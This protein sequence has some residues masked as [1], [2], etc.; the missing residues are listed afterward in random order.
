MIS[1]CCDITLGDSYFKIDKTV[2]PGLNWGNWKSLKLG[3]IDWKLWPIAGIVPIKLWIPSD[4]PVANCW[5][6]GNTPAI[7]LLN[8][9]WPGPPGLPVYVYCLRI[10]FNNYRF[11]NVFLISYLGLMGMLLPVLIQIRRTHRKSAYLVYCRQIVHRLQIIHHHHLQVNMTKSWIH[12]IILN[13][14]T[15]KSNLERISVLHHLRM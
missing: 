3:R 4:K 11:F 15:L 1:N 9:P 2:P 10:S 5:G 6:E 12:Q 8:A 7:A 13:E 14:K